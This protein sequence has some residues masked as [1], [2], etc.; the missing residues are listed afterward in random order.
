MS[1]KLRTLCNELLHGV[2]PVERD[3]GGGTPPYSN[4]NDEKRR[5]R[6]VERDKPQGRRQENPEVKRLEDD[7]TRCLGNQ[8]TS[9]FIDE[10]RAQPEERGR[11]YMPVEVSHKNLQHRDDETRRLYQEKINVH[12]T[13]HE[14]SS[15]IHTKGKV[16]QTTCNTPSQ[17]YVTGNAPV[18]QG[19]TRSETCNENHHLGNERTVSFVR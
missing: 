17:T 16:Q 1:A 7:E 11:A 12:Q 4:N 5:V 19:P 13:T 3:R 10:P 9:R 8:R 6:F 2:S 15:Q 18:Y 14:T